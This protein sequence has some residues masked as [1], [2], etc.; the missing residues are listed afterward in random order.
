M[1][2]AVGREEGGRVEVEDFCDEVM[3]AEKNEGR[4]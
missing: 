3:Q 1:S 4:T 2:S